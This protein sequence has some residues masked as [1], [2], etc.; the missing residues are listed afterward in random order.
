MTMFKHRAF[1]PL[2]T[3]LLLSLDSIA[4]EVDKTLAWAPG[5]EIKVNITAGEIKFHGWDKDEIKL[6]GDFSGDDNRLTFKK[7]GK[8][9][10]LELKDQDRGWWGNNSGGTVDFTVFAPFESDLDIDGTSLRI[11]VQDLHGSVEANSISGSVKMSG[12]SERVNVETVSGHIHIKDASGKMRLRTVSGSIDADV[13]ADTFDAKTVSG[14]IEGKIGRSEHA[15][16]LS[17]SGDVDIELSL[18]KDGRIEGQTVS[19]DLEINFDDTINADFELNTGPGGDISNR[20]SR[21]KPDDDNRWG[22]VLKFTL[23]DGDGTVELETMSGT[24][25]VR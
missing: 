2:A 21:D 22:Q 23:G 5:G 11:E 16:F 6:T 25:K 4:G 20:V 13:D 10:K 7:S 15:S 19:G 18:A 24:I 3:L 17:V 9:I 12:Q 1:L 14:D 8:N